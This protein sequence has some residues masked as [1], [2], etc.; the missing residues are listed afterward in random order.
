M[1]GDGEDS[2]ANSLKV[3]LCVS[4]SLTLGDALE[5]SGTLTQETKLSCMDTL[6]KVWFHVK[7]QAVKKLIGSRRVSPTHEVVL[8][9]LMPRLDEVFGMDALQGDFTQRDFPLSDAF[10]P[11]IANICNVAELGLGPLVYERQV[12]V[13]GPR[14]VYYVH[15]FFV[16]LRS[17]GRVGGLGRYCMRGLVRQYVW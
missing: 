2:N 16:E 1:G 13:E 11:Y 12:S 4:I 5:F 10:L 14:G 9:I 17:D 6:A 8:E 3:G 15:E 7:N